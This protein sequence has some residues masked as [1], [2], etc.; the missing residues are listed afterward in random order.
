VIIKVYSLAR[1][2]IAHHNCFWKKLGLEYS[3]FFTFVHKKDAKGQLS[4]GILALF[5]Y[6][7]YYSVKGIFKPG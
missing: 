4:I 5:G 6:I 3:P 2:V 1:I 7:L